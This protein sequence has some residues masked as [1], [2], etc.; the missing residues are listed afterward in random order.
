MYFFLLYLFFFWC[1]CLD[2]FL[3]ITSYCFLSSFRKGWGKQWHKTWEY[4]SNWIWFCAATGNFVIDWEPARPDLFLSTYAL[5]TTGSIDRWLESNYC[6][7]TSFVFFFFFFLQQVWIITWLLMWQRRKRVSNPEFTLW[8]LERQW[9]R[10]QRSYSCRT[11]RKSVS[12][13]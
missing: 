1:A 12:I 10:S 8:L 3:H 13:T 2:I 9:D 4:V 7:L 5:G 6:S 11:C